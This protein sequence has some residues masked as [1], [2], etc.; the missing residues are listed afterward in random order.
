MRYFKIY[1]LFGALISTNANAQNLLEAGK[2]Q[3]F[4][5]KGDLTRIVDEP[6]KHILHK[7]ERAIPNEACLLYTSRCV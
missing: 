3:L 2:Y 5:T 1:C 4:E 7:Y 6:Q